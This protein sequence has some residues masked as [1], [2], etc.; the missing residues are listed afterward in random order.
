VGEPRP[1]VAAEL[2]DGGEG[3]APAEGGDQAQGEDRYEGVA[4]AAGVPGVG[5]FGQEFDQGR[6]HE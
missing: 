1:A 3:R 4:E 5:E 6:G 2:G